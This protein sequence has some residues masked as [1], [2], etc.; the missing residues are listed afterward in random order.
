MGHLEELRVSR[1]NGWLVATIA[2]HPW[3][4]IAL[5]VALL[6]AL[7]PGLLRLQT[8]FTH[9]GFFNL[10]DP[11]LKKFEAFEKRFGNDDTVVI[12]VH[13]PSGVYDAAVACHCAGCQKL[14]A[15][16]II[17]AIASVCV[18]GFAT[19]D[20]MRSPTMNYL[21]SSSSMP[22]LAR[23]LRRSPRRSLRDSAVSPKH[24][25]PHVKG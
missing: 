7:G 1:F 18:S 22:Y 13:S 9:T 14:T 16:P 21:S 2:R 10:D 4:A 20:L 23:T 3:G 19:A 15:S 8:D 17:W 11:K 5:G 25:P 6:V 12:A 24:S